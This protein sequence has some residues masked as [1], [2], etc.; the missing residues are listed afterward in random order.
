MESET[1]RLL[2]LEAEIRKRIVGQEE[3]IGAV[4]DSLRRARSGLNDPRRPIGVFLFLG[5][6]GVGKSELARELAVQ[7]FDDEDALIRVD[8][9]EY[10]ERHSISRLFGARPDTSATTR[11]GS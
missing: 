7:M 8:M 3:A 11:P 1:E 10:T 4:A 2:N 5:P 9:S 6:T